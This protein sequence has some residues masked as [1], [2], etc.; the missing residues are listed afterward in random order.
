MDHGSELWTAD[1]LAAFYV[2]QHQCFESSADSHGEP[3]MRA[4]PGGLTWENLKWLTACTLVTEKRRVDL[5]EQVVAL[6]TWVHAS[7]AIQSQM[8]E[9]D[10][11]LK[12]SK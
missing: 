6:L 2:C 11:I 1:F 12:G 7:K 9:S 3:V 4:V 8:C 10:R 5:D